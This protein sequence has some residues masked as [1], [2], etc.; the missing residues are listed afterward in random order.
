[1]FKENA[2]EETKKYRINLKRIVWETVL[3]S[4]GAGF[5][6]ST[7][8]IFW[9]SIGMDQTAIG[10]VQMMFT[11]AMV[12]LDIPMGY[13][14]DRFNRKLLNVVG[15]IG[16]AA[17]FVFYAFSQNM[18]WAM[19][20]ECLLGLFMA[21]TN[22][23]DQSFIKYNCN[24][25]DSTGELF[26][27]TNIKVFTARYVALLM[28]VIIGGFIS[29]FDLRLTLALSFVPYFIGGLIACGI[30][31]F[32][33]K[34]E[35]KHK[36]PVKDMA[37][38]VK[39]IIKDAKTRTLMFAYVLG[40]ELTHAQIWV[41][42]P[43]M[44]LVGVPIEIVSMG[45]AINYLAQIVGSKFSEKFIHLKTSNK[46]AIP[47]AIEFVWIAI[48]VFQTN[49]VTVW[50]FALNGFVHG[51][52]EGN[53]MTPLQEA[54]K[55]EIQTSVMSVASTGARLLYVPLVYIINYLGNTKLELAL[56]GVIFIFLP[57]SI[58]TYFKL[59]KIEKADNILL[60]DSNYSE[61]EEI[62]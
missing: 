28:V 59:R 24:K 58:V 17:T 54:T 9:N 35:V 55:D 34:V 49:I 18:Y 31:D 13:I 10:F 4:I 2:S 5:S 38:N 57:L 30:K 42:T 47:F 8:T 14:A 3:T 48:L 32:D 44:I 40:K 6:V 11:I 51:V 62:I 1:M 52:L 37:I 45:W 20:S 26:K 27:K 61:S 23:V 7:V 33:A 46:F 60:L 22:G 16:V 50:L 53:L 19:I 15:D 43:L 36:N 21:M 39:E 29:K 56:V 25:I 41:F 12:L